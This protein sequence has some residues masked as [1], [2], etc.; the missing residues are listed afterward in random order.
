MAAIQRVGIAGTGSYIPKRKIPNS[1]FEDIVDTS[2]EWIKQRT[3]IEQRFFVEEGETTSSMCI[4]AG[5]KALEAAGLKADDI[6]LIIV[7]T[8]TPDHLL[9]SCSGRVQLGLGA[10][11]AGAFDCNAACTGFMT[12]MSI[13]ESFIRAGRAKNVM[14]FGAESL[15]R[16]IN[17]EDRGSCILFG[18]GAGAA[19]LTPWEDC[20]QGEILETSLGADGSG[21][22]HIY[23][24]GGGSEQPPTHETVDAKIHFITVKGREVYRFAVNKMTGL[25]NEMLVGHDREELGMIVPHQ[26]NLR[27]IESALEKLE[28]PMEQC[29]VNIQKYGNTSAATIPIALDEAVRQGCLE[30][31]KLVLMAAF[32]A[33]L[34]WGSVKVRW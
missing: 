12:A 23:M 13:G 22:E 32:G 26:V 10:T 18:D 30:K 16:F 19:I 5:K 15:S 25:I 21:Y 17:F 20:K 34:T 2:D 3:G 24:Q 28:I 8:L 33:G 29:F 27:I 11:N 1:F 31:D 14:V 4:E 6:D 9:P 7:G